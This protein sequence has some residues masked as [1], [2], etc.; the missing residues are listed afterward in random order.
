MHTQPP[1]TLYMRRKIVIFQG[2]K[3]QI[4]AKF[5][6]ISAITRKKYLRKFDVCVDACVKFT[7]LHFF[8]QNREFGACVDACAKLR[9]FCAKIALLCLYTEF[10]CPFLTEVRV[11]EWLE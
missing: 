1:G 3:L 5:G 4:C 8:A 10:T 9:Q 6:A 11:A 7:N 2:V